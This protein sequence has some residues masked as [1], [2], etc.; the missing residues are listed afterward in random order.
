MTHTPTQ[1]CPKCG[2]YACIIR[3]GLW[4]CEVPVMSD[5]KVRMFNKK[6]RAR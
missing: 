4:L 2:S 5:E 3:S 6:F 1:P